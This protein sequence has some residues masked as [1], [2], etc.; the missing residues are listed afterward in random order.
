MW[1]LKEKK[2][3]SFLSPNVNER[4]LPEPYSIMCQSMLGFRSL[5]F[6]PSPVR[7]FLLRK[8]K[9][10]RNFEV[11][12]V[13]VSLSLLPVK[14]QRH[15]T[16]TSHTLRE[17]RRKKDEKDPPFKNREAG[18][19]WIEKSKS[20]PSKTIWCWTHK[21]PSAPPPPPTF[22]KQKR[23]AYRSQ[24]KMMMRRGKKV[25]ES[26]STTQ[27][28]VEAGKIY[29]I[30]RDDDMRNHRRVKRREGICAE[31]DGMMMTAGD[32]SFTL[33]TNLSGICVMQTWSKSYVISDHI[34][35]WA[36][37]GREHLL[38]LWVG[39][40]K[41]EKEVKKRERG[42]ECQKCVFSCKTRVSTVK[43]LSQLQKDFRKTVEQL[44]RQTAK[45]CRGWNDSFLEKERRLDQI[46]FLNHREF[47]FC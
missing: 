4:R 18:G 25:E 43:L 26:H 24:K 2:G 33:C 1:H 13:R 27:R 35:S 30:L 46:C 19:K 16:R 15:T 8:R 36:T 14:R 5:C 3:G 37:T 17:K 6:F 20:R 21:R 38:L 44:N 32:Y 10:K 7:T 12:K 11:R 40:K 47:S 23:H 9:W 39:A 29:K 31:R 22:P 45:W 42:I 41:K 28:T 34:N